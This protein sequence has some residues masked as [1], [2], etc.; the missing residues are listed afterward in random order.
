MGNRLP[1]GQ[2]QKIGELFD[3]TTKD[4]LSFIE[5]WSTV[6][7]MTA[8]AVSFSEGVFSYY[9]RICMHF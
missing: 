8:T 1:R 7:Q 2:M 4:K 6:E 9:F 5:F 3:R